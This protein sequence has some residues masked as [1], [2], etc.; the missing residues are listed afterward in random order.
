MKVAVERAPI[1]EI[2]QPIKVMVTLET[3]IEAQEFQLRMALYGSELQKSLQGSN[4]RTCDTFD[5]AFVSDMGVSQM[6]GISGLRRK[7]ASILGPNS[8]VFE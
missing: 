3:L 1:V 5:T 4:N 6:A 8:V 2:F 7:L